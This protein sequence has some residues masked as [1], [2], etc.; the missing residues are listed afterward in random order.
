MGQLPTPTGYGF[1]GSMNA[2]ANFQ[3]QGSSGATAVKY[4]TAISTS[5]VMTIVVGGGGGN[6]GQGIVIVEF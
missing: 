1:G 2:G 6:G 5:Q 3:S 4:F